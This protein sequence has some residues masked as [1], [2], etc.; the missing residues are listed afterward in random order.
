MLNKSPFIFLFFLFV[1]SV[2]FAQIPRA[3]VD[4]DTADINTTL[5]V[6]APGVL[7]NDTE[8]SGATLTVAQFFVDGVAF[9]AGD[10]A[11]FAE[12]SIT[13]LGDGSYTFVPRADYTGNVSTITYQITN[14]TLTSSAN[15]FLT[16]EFTNDLLVV[17]GLRSCNQGFNSN[18]EYKIVYSFELNNTSNARDFHETSLIK[19]INIT[20]NLEAAFGTGCIINIDNV[21]IF[22]RSDVTYVDTPYP[23]EFDDSTINQD[24][25]NVRSSEF[26]S[27]A[28]TTNLT[29]YPRQS[30]FVSYCVTVNPFCNGRSNPTP[31]GSGINF[32]NTFSVNSTKGGNS[33]AITL[34]DFHTTEA[35]VSAGLHVPEFH[36]NQEN[37]PGLVNSDGTYDYINTVVIT[38]EGSSVAQNINFNM[39]LGDFE[40][41]VT[42]NEIRVTQ[43][44]G[45]NVT[46]NTNFNGD[47][48]T[49]LLTSNNTLPPGETIILEVFYLIG[50]V[51]SQSYSFFN[52]TDLSQTQSDLDG[53]DAENQDNKKTFS[54]VT[55]S[56]NL[57]NHLDRYYVLN[58][59]ETSV[60]SS[61]YCDCSLV[62]MRFLFSASSNT[63][64]EITTSIPEPNGILEHEEITFQT[65]IENTSQAV[66]LNNLQLE[67]NVNNVCGGNIIS[68][69]TPTIVSSSA[70]TNP[71]LNPS[72]N[73]VS[74]TNLFDGTSGLLKI[75]EKITV[76]Y[77]VV[78]SEACLGNNTSFFSAQDPLGRQVSSSNSITVIAAT[79]TD[80]DGITNDVDLDD[81]N[82]TI[83]D[84]LEYN[85]LD[86]LEDADADDIPNY[87][88]VDFGTDANA[89]GIID[90]FD[91]DNDGVPNHFDL[92]SENDGILDIVE[93][94]NSGLD[95]SNNG[96]TN[97]NVGSNGLDNTL[98]S[99]DSTTASIIYTIANTDNNG[100]PNFLDIDADDD[101][102]VDVIEAQATNNFI[103]LN[104]SVSE[105]GI[106]IAHPNGIRPVDTENDGIPDYID[107]NSDDDIRDDVLEGWDT[108]SDGTAEVVPLNSDADNDGLDDAFDNDDTRLNQTNGQTPQSFPNADNTDNPERD[109]R[110]II[111]IVILID[112]ITVT[113][114]EEIT[115]TILFVTKNNNTISIESASPVDINFS[116]SNGSTTTDVYDV[117]IAPFDYPAVT[118]TTFTI[119]PFTNTA[120]FTITSLED[121]IYELTELFT[122]TGTVT[123]NN[124]LTKQFNG[125]VSLL[126]NDD[127]PP[128]E[129]NNTKEDEGVNLVHTIT[130]GNPC[131]TPIEIAVNTSDNLAISPDDYN[132]TSELLTING[133]IDPNNANT[134]V[135]FSITSLLDNLNELDEEP[136]NVVGVVQTTNVG[137]QDLT[138]TA[139][140]VDIDP[141]PLVQIDSV[142][143]EEGGF[144]K[145][146]IRLLNNNDELM[147]N[148][149]PINMILETVDN[150]ASATLD[151]EYKSKQI[152]IPAFTESITQTINTLDDTLNEDTET[153]FLQANPF[154]NDVSNTFSPKGLGTI[155]DNDYPNLFSPNGDG[156]SDVFE[157]SGI[158]DYP[159]FKI[160]IYNRQGNEVYNYSN[161]GNVNPVWWNGTQKGQPVPT[162][163]YYYILDFNDGVKKP[164]TK[165]IQLIR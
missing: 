138:K 1:S 128:I 139:T 50:P 84:V 142:T 146:T 20:N 110:E 143:T 25:V 104:G 68:V 56:D 8:S 81:D 55:W 21:N 16:V 115:F 96:R 74:D 80:N 10:T 108:N 43:V 53:F 165:F 33:E 147:Q 117:A 5:S 37:P 45:P 22:T 6:A 65:T 145:F 73:G 106:D 94:G 100:N 152:T 30:I 130:I 18:G 71:I 41:K 47:D 149:L 122:L 2:V 48:E 82:D 118:N 76:E 97:S 102:I 27:T 119:S 144:L 112:D 31:S 150:T 151:Y 89:D 159:N 14:G 12:G 121:T 3:R 78:F 109:W 87:R 36:S 54:Y 59:L 163:V 72:F 7:V 58:A 57:G 52:Q 69:S 140:I 156:K 124:T 111:A 136:L 154:S 23:R 62:G 157:I 29:L 46:V 70:T 67:E 127:P 13:I 66:E 164:I 107:I 161:N 99:N 113:E 98:E 24:F 132:P 90:M 15:L 95:T 148:Y 126:D 125:I 34:T 153:F 93:A 160:K 44:S 51:D 88:D 42:F 85:G 77:T 137:T 134:E 103:T 17:R 61:L 35:V 158:E 91:F 63:N 162:G 101:G 79:D 19:N 116:T 155:K 32:T 141:K 26:L 4:Y 83:P 39:G 131:S 75:T 9:N 135:S 38:N 49:L 92:D 60:S 114:G 120:Q 133:T 123:S 28:A 40:D 86:P 129:M 105:W 11:N 64:N